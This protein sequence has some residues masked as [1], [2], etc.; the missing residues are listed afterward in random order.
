MI[1]SLFPLL[2]TSGWVVAANSDALNLTF[3]MIN[4]GSPFFELIQH[5][6]EYKCKDT[7]GVT[8]HVRVLTGNSCDK[9]NYTD[10]MRELISMNL[11]GIA[12]SPQC[13]VEFMEPLIAEAFE[14]GVPIVTF[15]SDVPNSKRVAYVGTDNVFLGRTMAK[16]LRQLRPDGGTY[17]IVSPKEG[18]LEGF[19]KEI[20]RYNDQDDRAHWYEVAGSQEGVE[21]NRFFGL[22]YM[23]DMEK[24]ALLNTSAMIIMKQSPMRQTNWTDFVDAYRHRNITYIGVDA[25]D[26][27]LSYLNQRY[28]DGLVGQLPYVIGTD[29]FQVLYDMATKGSL[30]KTVFKTNLV[31]Y[32]LIPIELPPLDVDQNLLGNFK[33]FGITCFGL[34]ALSAAGCVAWTLYQ[35]AS[36]VVGAA[37]P[38]FLVMVAAGVL[39]MS[40]SLVPLSF[41]DGGNLLDDGGNLESISTTRSV[42]ICMSIPWLAFTGFTMTFSALFSKTWR[43]NRLFHGKARHTRMQVSEK[44]VLAPFAVLLTSNIVVLICWT[45]LDPLTYVREEQEGT[46]YWNRVISTSGACRSDNVVAY[47]VPLAVINLSVVA[48]ACWQALQ[49]SNI[50][51]EFSEAKYIGL[52]VASLFQ[53]FVTGIPV[54]VV[55]RDTPQTFYVVLSIT[56]FLL[57]MAVLLLIFLP[58]MLMQRKYAGKSEAEQRRM[59]GESIKRSSADFKKN[60]VELYTSPLSAAGESKEIPLKDV[61]STDM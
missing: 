59:I 44:A 16:L 47:L 40:S 60:S 22:D 28:V 43:V 58:K 19:V 25:A 5:G 4:S 6:W 17:A 33:Y 30:E 45:V 39:I 7:L 61:G 37:Q 46:D 11:D 54:V 23:E 27:Q 55:V 50:K 8:C 48:T 42:G 9:S 57:C 31:A 26:Y 49:A 20:T 56:M 24:Y 18:R 38:F 2:F 41:D 35:R 15:D 12:V 53:A 52:A 32:N 21:G 29:S 51:S 34:V 36:Y 10:I 13:T 14:A 3:G 1:T